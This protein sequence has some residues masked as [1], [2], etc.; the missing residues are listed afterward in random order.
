[1]PDEGQL[2]ELFHS[3]NAIHTVVSYNWLENR[4]CQQQGGTFGLVFGQLAS[5]VQDV[6]SDK[7]G[8]WS[9]LLF[10]GRD[11]HKVRIVT[12]YQPNVQK[13]T[14][15]GLVNHQHWC[16]YLEEGLAPNMDHI[17]KFMNDL[18]AQLRQWW[19][20]HEHL[21]LF[22]DAKENTTNGPLNTAL[23]TPDLLM[24]EGVYSLHPDLPQT[25]SFQCGDC[26]GHHPIDAEYLTPD[27]PLEAGTRMSKVRSPG[28]HQSCFVEICWKA[29]VCKDLFKIAHP[30]AQRLS[31]TAYSLMVE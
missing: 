20:T 5:K 24:G 16:Q 29:L 28:D 3:E 27:L 14:M 7:L 8:R 17:A 15:L 12:A 30:D 1:M 19:Q 22:I 31:S 2:P 21:I 9:W 18:V 11:G 23:G 13:A 25:P 4:G 6:G 26:I 10:W